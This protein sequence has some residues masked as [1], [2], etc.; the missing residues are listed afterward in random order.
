[1]DGYITANGEHILVF[2]NTDANTNRNE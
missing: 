1:M 2:K